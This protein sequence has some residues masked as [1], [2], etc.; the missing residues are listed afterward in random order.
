SPR[1]CSST[2]SASARPPRSCAQASAPPSPMIRAAPAIWAG[3]A[4]PRALRPQS[5]PPWDETSDA[6]H[7]RRRR[8]APGAHVAYYAP[9]PFSLLL[10]SGAP[11]TFHLE[12]SDA[13]HL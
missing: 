9:L 6:P 5:A 11:Q 13:P 2:I 4:I 10:A 1:P 12:A 3:R 7:L 8:C